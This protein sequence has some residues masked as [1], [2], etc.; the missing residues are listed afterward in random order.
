MIATVLSLLL[1]TAPA[2]EAG[3]VPSSDWAANAKYFALTYHPDGGENE[4]YPLQLDDE[5]YWVLQVGA[6]VDVDR[7]LTSWLQMRGTVAL[8]RDCA[9]VW[10]GLVSLGPRLEWS[11]T[12]NLA[13][14][15]GVGPTFLWRENWLFHVKGYTKDS[16]FGKADSSSD[17]QS[18]FLWYGGDLEAQWRLNRQWSVVASVVPGWPEVITSSVGARREF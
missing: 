15:F 18:A 10:A 11:P 2:S 13:F 8:Y 16:F 4:G 5:A 14:R 9:N 1:G 12:E 17:F 7:R 3:A 6:Q